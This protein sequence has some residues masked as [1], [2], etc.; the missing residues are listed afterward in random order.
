M[1]GPDSPAT[2]LVTTPPPIA[3]A[4]K[5]AETIELY[6]EAYL[7]DVPFADY[8]VNPVVQQACNDLSRL[9]DFRGPKIGGAVTPQ[10]LFRYNYP[11]CLDGPMASQI[12][13]RNFAYDGIQITPLMRTRQPCA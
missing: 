7:R 4:A 13:Y 3:S 5:A 6:W 8:N 11:G 12:L 2:S 9:S 10:S 1:E